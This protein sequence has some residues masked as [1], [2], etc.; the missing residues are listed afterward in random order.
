MNRSNKTI[1]FIYYA[2]L[3]DSSEEWEIGWLE[4]LL[5]TKKDLNPNYRPMNYS[6]T[7]N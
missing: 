3:G 6:L 5:S 1:L 4:F 7:Q 2:S